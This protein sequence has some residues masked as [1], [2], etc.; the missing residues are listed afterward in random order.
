MSRVKGLGLWGLGFRVKV[1]VASFEVSGSRLK[2]SGFEITKH[3]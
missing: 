3:G 1:L 2:A